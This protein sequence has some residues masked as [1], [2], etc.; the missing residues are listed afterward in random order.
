[1]MV[2]RCHQQAVSA[3]GARRCTVACLTPCA[4]SFVRIEAIVVSSAPAIASDYRPGPTVGSTRQTTSR[5]RR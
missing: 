5:S 3:D 4:L 1:M 2:G